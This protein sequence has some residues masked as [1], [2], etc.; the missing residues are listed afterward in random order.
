M[1]EA[2][3]AQLDRSLSIMLSIQ[4]SKVVRKQAFLSEAVTT[5]RRTYTFE[6]V[7]CA[8]HYCQGFNNETQRRISGAICAVKTDTHILWH[9]QWVAIGWKLMHMRLFNN[10]SILRY[11]GQYLKC[12]ELHS[13]KDKS[14]MLAFFSY[15][16]L[17][18]LVAKCIS[19]G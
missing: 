1:T 19:W 17:D 6:L 2:Y 13:C 9:A 7:C 10:I 11:S 3:S 16:C 18:L 5:W 12:H 8:A 15:R 14:I 4:A